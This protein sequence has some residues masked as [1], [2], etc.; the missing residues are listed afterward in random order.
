MHGNWHRYDI[1][2]RKPVVLQYID[3]QVQENISARN[4][5]LEPHMCETEHV[6]I[7]LKKLG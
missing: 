4:F 7:T 2:L 3:L 1:Y 5:W 6:Y